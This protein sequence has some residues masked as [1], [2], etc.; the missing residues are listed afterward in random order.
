MDYTIQKLIYEAQPRYYVTAHLY[1]PH[2]DGPF[3]ATICPVGHWYEGKAHGDYQ[4]LGS[5]LARSG[6]ITLIYDA[7][8]QGERLMYYDLLLRES[9]MGKTVTDEH[10]MAGYACFLT[11]S[12]LAM[13]MIWDGMRTIDLLLDREDVDSKRIACTGSS[14]G[15]GL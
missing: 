1:R 11:G 8:G 5:C 10:C 9:W 12:H 15:G 2:G 6:S 7:P 4:A 13:H 14:G 3:P